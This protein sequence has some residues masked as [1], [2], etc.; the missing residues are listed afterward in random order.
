MFFCLLAIY[1]NA[2]FLEA[3]EILQNKHNTGKVL[4][5]AHRGDWR[6]APENSIRAFQ[7]AV[8][9]GVHFIEVDVQLSK[10]SVLFILHDNAFDRT[11]NKKG[12]PGDYDWKQIKT[13][14]LRNGQGRVTAHTIPS[15]QDVFE[16]FKNEVFINI[17]KGYKHLPEVIKIIQLHEMEDYVYISIDAGV[18]LEDIHKKYGY[19]PENI[20]LM[21]II[22]LNDPHFKKYVDSYRNRKNII[23]QCVFRNEDMAAFEIIRNLKKEGYKIW[24]NSLWA[25]LC[26]GH[27][28]D[29]AVEDNQ[30]DE[31]WGWLIEM[32]A[33]I[34]Q[35]DRPKELLEYLKSK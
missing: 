34:I 1:S 32:G 25:S 2:Q 17:D 26:A 35:T 31:T 16:K 18:S 21:P 23:Y 15:L 5:V 9:L 12:K 4:V 30:K 27:D 3:K 22:N 29:R 28:D 19:L 14:K 13:F 11:T 7:N 10:D 20:R 6:N 33:D 24:Y 8:D